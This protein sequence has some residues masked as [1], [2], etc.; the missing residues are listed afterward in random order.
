MWEKGVVEFMLYVTLA[1]SLIAPITSPSGRSDNKAPP[2]L[3]AIGVGTFAVA[4]GVLL[5][6]ASLGRPLS[7][8]DGLV[9]QDSFTS[10]MLLGSSVAAIVFL[11]SVG[12]DGLR[13]SSSPSLYSLVPM[14]LFGAFFLA[15]AANFLVILASW[16]LVSV[17][18]YVVMAMPD[19]REAK[20]A[21]VRYI[22]V[23]IV[24]TLA[25]VAS[26]AFMS[27][28]SGVYSFSLS[29]LY[30]TSEGA[31]GLLA[32]A[33]L[34]LMA[35][36]GFKVGIFP[37]HWWLPSVYGR[38]DGRAV[39]FVAAVVKLAFLAV[40]ARVVVSLAAGGQ[41]YEDIAITLAAISVAT[42]TY[43]NVAALTS[44]DLQVILAYS[45]MAQVGYIFAAMAAAAYFAGVGNEYMLRISMFSVA[46]QSIA[47]AIAKAPLFSFTGS[48]GKSLESLRGLMKSS[49]ATSVA[50][51]ILLYSLLGVPPL[52]GFWGKLYMFLAAVG[53][54]VWLALAALI[55]S[56]ISSVYYII[57]SRE[58]LRKDYDATPK[59]R[60]RLI[61]ALVV[62][63]LLIIVLGIVA[64]LMLRGIVSIYL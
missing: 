25:L 61:T 27:L 43:G 19:A 36:L 22:Y 10:L 9:V 56:G 51:S 50:A 2:V 16:L 63:S 5:Y 52:L 57:A 1:T 37:F 34:L 49:P 31:R 47:Y 23:G 18:S 3:A 35:A 24:A 39:S 45:S 15:G 38:G 14:S 32:V 30:V 8:F 17:I 21:A 28:A 4:S 55:N 20:A 6:A 41:V 46:L 42:M 48:V 12:D 33:V 40:I 44:R 26:L 59:P 13:W 64:P 7:F 54:T 62:A 11:I 58:L 53:F 60:A 29:S